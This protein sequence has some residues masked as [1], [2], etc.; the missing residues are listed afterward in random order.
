MMVHACNP[1]FSG[2]GDQEDHSSRTAWAKKIVRPH[3][4]KKKLGLVAHNCHPSYIDGIIRMI[5]KM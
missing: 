4:N 5:T 3:L 2:D 1:S